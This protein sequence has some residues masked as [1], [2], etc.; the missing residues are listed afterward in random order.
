[1]IGR[2]DQDQ[3]NTHA[4]VASIGDEHFSPERPKGDLVLEGMAQSL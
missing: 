2:V 1:M 3:E 4:T